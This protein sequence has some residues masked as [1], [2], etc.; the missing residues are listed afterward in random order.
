MKKIPVSIIFFFSFPFFLFGFFVWF[1]CLVAISKIMAEMRR[2][3]VPSS[4]LCVDH[5][6]RGAPADARPHARRFF[7]FRLYKKKL[8]ALYI[9]I[10]K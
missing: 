10:Y 4:H 8:C 7:F 9:N 2:K 6:D 1:I 3:Q 5:R